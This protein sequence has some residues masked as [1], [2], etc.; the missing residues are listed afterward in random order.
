M[1]DQGLKL[2]AEDEEDL[3]ILSAHL[4]DAVMRIGDMAYLPKSQRFA[5][6]VNRFCWE[7]CAEERIGERVRAGLHFDGVMKVQAQN[8]RQDQPDAV[9]ELLAL[10]FTPHDG[11]G[12]IVELLLAGGGRVRLEVEY[13]DAA[14]RDITEHWP[15][16]A[17][18][19]HDLETG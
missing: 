19:E 13:I 12:G 7:G 8:V 9:V 1:T 2:L 17:R 14:L 5:A 4:Q 6:L 15:A 18:P 11:V 10:K 16:V 3:K